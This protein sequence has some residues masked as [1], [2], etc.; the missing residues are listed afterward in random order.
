MDLEAR[1]ALR[2]IA[3]NQRGLFSAAQAVQLGIEHHQ[4]A[5]AARHGYLR[6]VRRG[7]YAVRGAPR[8]HWEDLVA[9]ALA[10]GPGAAISHTSAAAVH[11]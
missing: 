11:H 4:L 7:V 10:A 1:T 5:W 8:S 2:R 3:E 9:A 6:R